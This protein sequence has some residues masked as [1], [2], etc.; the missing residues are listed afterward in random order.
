MIFVEG[1]KPVVTEK[2]ESEY[3]D[4]A[5]ILTLLEHSENQKSDAGNNITDFSI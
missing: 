1:I 4:E 5:K 2:D 3:R